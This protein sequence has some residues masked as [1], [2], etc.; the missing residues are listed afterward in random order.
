[1]GQRPTLPAYLRPSK[2][3]KSLDEF[4]DPPWKGRVR[5]DGDDRVTVKGVVRETMQWLIIFAMVG[6][7][8]GLFWLWLSGGESCA[9]FASGFKMGWC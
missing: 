3:L 5:F 2:R 6:I 9:E 1:M 7:V 8:G 4:E